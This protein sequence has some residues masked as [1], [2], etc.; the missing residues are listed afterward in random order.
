M[1]R[2]GIPHSELENDVSHVD[3]NLVLAR[4]LA[5]MTEV[6]QQNCP[7]EREQ[8]SGCP[9]ERF[10]AHGT[11]AFSGQEDPLR[12]GRWISDLEKMFEICGCSEAQK[13]L[14]ASYL[15]QGDAT[16]WWETKREL[17]EMELGSIAAVSWVRFKKEFNDRFFPI[18]M[19]KQMAREFNNLVQGEM[20]VEQYARKF[21]ELG[22]FATHLIATEEMRIERF[23]EGLHREI[24]RQVACLQILTFQQ[25]VEVATIAEREFIDHFATPIGHEEE[26][27]IM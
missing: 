24:R 1:D 3:E 20:T 11:P 27:S 6:L 15:L 14:Y 23:Q 7:P 16:A 25:L 17:L 22:K 21:I 2:S 12:A 18:S 13:V 8:Q 4:A 26:R 19:R 5:R 10:L 9:Y